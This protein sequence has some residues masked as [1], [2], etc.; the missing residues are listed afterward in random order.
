MYKSTLPIT[1][2]SLG[3]T[4]DE[5]TRSSNA[6]PAILITS[7]SLL[8]TLEDNFAASIVKDADYFLGHSSGEYTAAVAS[9]FISFA[10]GVRLTVRCC[11]P[12]DSA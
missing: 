12:L 11:P 4:Q 9:Q 6:Q 5:L 10:D 8:K 3:S 7:I 2:P 1:D